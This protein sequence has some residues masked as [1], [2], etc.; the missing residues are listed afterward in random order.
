MLE[1]MIDALLSIAL[2]D[3]RIHF[4]EERLIFAALKIFQLSRKDYDRIKHR[5]EWRSALY[6]KREALKAG[7]HA[8]QSEQ[9]KQRIDRQNQRSSRR[10]H[11]SIQTPL[12]QESGLARACKILGVTTHASPEI[13]K[14]AYRKLVLTHHPDRLAAQGLP[15]EFRAMAANRFRE[16]QEAF[17]FI[18]QQRNFV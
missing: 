2:A 13:I 18:Q 7:R 3:R 15:E 11:S 14:K 8:R 4:D 5:H 9:D 6:Q 16:I 17:E 12:E 1:N 10:M